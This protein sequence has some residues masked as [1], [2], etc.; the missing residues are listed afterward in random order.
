MIFCERCFK[1]IEI[2]YH[3]N[4]WKGNDF[5]SVCKGQEFV[6]EPNEQAMEWVKNIITSK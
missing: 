4:A 3:K 2:S 5:Y 6:F 1:D